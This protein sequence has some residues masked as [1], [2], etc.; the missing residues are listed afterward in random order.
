MG[1]RLRTKPGKKPI[2]GAVSELLKRRFRRGS[3]RY[4]RWYVILSGLLLAAFSLGTIYYAS[5]P[6][7]LKIAIDSA[8]RLNFYELQ[9]LAATLE[10][11]GSH[12]KLALVSTSGPEETRSKLATGETELAVLRANDELPENARAVVILRKTSILLLDV[13]KGSRTVSLESLNGRRIGLVVE[14]PRDE[15][16]ARFVLNQT[17]VEPQAM[18]VLA[19]D[20]LK[21]ALLNKTFDLFI[22][23]GVIP[24]NAISQ[25]VNTIVESVEEPKLLSIDAS[26]AINSRFPQYEST[27]IAQ[28]A[29]SVRPTRPAEKLDTLT[30]ADLLV[31]GKEVSGTTIA[32]L[33]RLLLSDNTWRK[34]GHAKLE[35]VST[36]K[37]APL[38][39]HDG[40]AAFIDGTERTFIERYGDVF[41]FTLVL[42]SGLGS[43]GVGLRSFL[44]Y[45]ERRAN[46][47]LRRHLILMTEKIKSISTLS[48][49]EQLRA[50]ADKILDHT[51]LCYDEGAIDDGSL[52]AFELLAMRFYAKASDRSLKLK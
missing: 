6:I 10:R 41:W 37:D 15:A 34:A 2:E 47:R 40:T 18:S 16:F 22:L 11:E 51:L 27:E 28:G 21:L 20:Q 8:A 33:T 24:S 12:L 4:V 46:D 39:A 23:S 30:V 44:K 1:L 3:S 31:A 32:D 36:D 19:P 48:E 42:A 43:A 9:E 45:D 50:E 7:T 49:L 13:R 29:I 52:S 5:R 17:G 25:A 26:D 35:A 14:D 38:L